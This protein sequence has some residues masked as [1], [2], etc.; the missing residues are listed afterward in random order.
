MMKQSDWVIKNI[1]NMYLMP[2]ERDKEI[3]YIKND[4]II[5]NIDQNS[6]SIFKQAFFAIKKF[7]H[8]LFCLDTL[9][10]SI[11]HQSSFIFILV[12]LFLF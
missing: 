3:Q 4:Q 11:L 1:L 9:K 7:Y 12:I 6:S 2:I 8:I 10:C 5:S